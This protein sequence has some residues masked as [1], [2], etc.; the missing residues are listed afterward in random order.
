MTEIFSGLSDAWIATSRLEII[1]VIF[2]LAYI[3]LAARE[4]S[5]CWP[6]AFIGTGT[7]ILL[8]WDASLL[9]E[10]GLNLYYLAMAV[11]GW[12]QWR[13]GGAKGGTLA[14]SSWKVKEHLLA[15]SIIVLLTIASGA[16][17][18]SKTSAAL[19]YLDSFT[20]W[21]AV[22][23]TWMVACKILQNWLYWIVIDALSIYLYMERGLYLYAL[24]FLLYVFIAV[25]GYLNWQKSYNSNHANVGNYDTA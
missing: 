24:L 18:A 10:S 19:P 8:F 5:W 17:L 4:N 23:T 3:V 14:I 1:S 13:K 7:A 15:I 16:L 11:F 20:T 12:W 21:A 6:A 2:G 22:L 25:F 9:M